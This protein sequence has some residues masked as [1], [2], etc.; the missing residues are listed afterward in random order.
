MV[1]QLELIN[2]HQNFANY[3]NQQKKSIYYTICIKQNGWKF[4]DE[5]YD[6]YN[7]TDAL[8]NNNNEIDNVYTINEIEKALSD[9][10]EHIV[11]MKLMVIMD[12]KNLIKHLNQ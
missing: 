10:D 9:I 7:E 3:L 5:T 8:M 11:Q 6:N 4:N 2:L 12:Q 1:L